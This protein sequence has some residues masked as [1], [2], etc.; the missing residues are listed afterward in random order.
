MNWSDIT[1][2]FKRK[3]RQIERVIDFIPIIWKGYD[4]DYRYSIELFKKSLERQANF[5]ES[6]KAY[7]MEAKHNASRIRTAIR[8]ID[9]VYDEEYGMS[10]IYEIQERYGNDVLEWEFEDTG[11]GTGSSYLKYKYEKWNNANEIKKVKTELIKK[12]NEKQKKAHK[13]LWNFVEHNIHH[14]WD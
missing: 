1:Y 4:F 6:D 14:W 8:L 12:S 10:W 2:F 5:L 7:T 11:D 13:L 3:Y 9:K